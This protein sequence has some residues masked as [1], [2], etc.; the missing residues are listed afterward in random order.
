MHVHQNTTLNT[1][2]WDNSLK[3]NVLNEKQLP[4]SHLHEIKTMTKMYKNFME[5]LNLKVNH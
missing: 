5:V 4:L 3:Q 2:V 1:H